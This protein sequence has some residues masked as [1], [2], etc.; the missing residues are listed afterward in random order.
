MQ[1]TW[2]PDFLVRDSVTDRIKPFQFCMVSRLNRSVSTG[3]SELQFFRNFYMGKWV[4]RSKHEPQIQL[5]TETKQAH[6]R[7][8]GS[9]FISSFCSVTTTLFGR[10]Y[11]R[12]GDRRE[13]WKTACIN[14]LITT[15]WNWTAH[16]K[17]SNHNSSHTMSA[18]YKSIV[19][20]RWARARIPSTQL[21]ALIAIIIIVDI[22]IAIRTAVLKTT[23]NT[24]VIIV[25]IITTIQINSR[26]ARL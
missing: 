23:I 13:C 21:V 4:A 7:F 22:V 20:V 25:I 12:V 18:T 3:T 26:F 16:N 6:H 2:L 15:V 8:V 10:A 14:I 24:L 17:L 1:L 9:I 11:D 19:S 5:K